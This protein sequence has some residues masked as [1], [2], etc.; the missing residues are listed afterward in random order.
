MSDDM[1]PTTGEEQEHSNSGLLLSV[2]PLPGTESYKMSADDDTADVA[3]G[4]TDNTDTS[5][6]D[7]SDTA[8]DKGDSDADGTDASDADG[9]D[10]GLDA[11][12]SRPL[13]ISGGDDATDAK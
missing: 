1:R 9:T 5:D 10:T 7:G 13:G 12:G 6:A 2:D 3:G 11:D 4:D 8:T